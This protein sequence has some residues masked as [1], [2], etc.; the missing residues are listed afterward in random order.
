MNVLVL[1]AHPEEKS[2]SSSLKNV[3][4]EHFEKEGHEVVVKDLYKMNFNPILG[5]NDFKERIDSDYLQILKEQGHATATDSFTDELKTEMDA[6]VKADL[7]LLNFPVSWS[8]FPA[9]LKGWFERVIA[10]NF[11]YHPKNKQYE[12]GVFKGKKVMCCITTGSSKFS[13]SEE[14]KHGDIDKLLDHI[15]HGLLY[16]V[17]MTVLPPFYTWKTHLVDETTLK[18]YIEEYKEHLT[19]LDNFTPIYQ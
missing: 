6:L 5:S 2:F 1:H 13:Y 9:I 16:Y 19:N 12:T 4:V 3:A 14:G 18:G 7:L 15:Y 8:S 11:A 10:F 17:G